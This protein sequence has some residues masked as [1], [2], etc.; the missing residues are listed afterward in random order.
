MNRLLPRSIRMRVDEPEP[1]PVGHDRFRD[2]T[3][4][5]Y[6]TG[7]W[8]WDPMAPGD[9]ALARYTHYATFLD[10]AWYQ[11]GLMAWK[12][13]AWRSRPNFVAAYNAA[14][15]QTGVDYRIEWRTH[16]ALWAARLALRVQ[17]DFIELGAA[18]GWMSAAILADVLATEPDRRFFLMDLFSSG[19]VDPSTGARLDEVSPIYA[20]GGEA[21][22]P[23]VER[24]LQVRVVEGDVMDT[25]HGVVSAAPRIAFAHF[26]LNAAEPEMLAFS[27]LRSSLL[28]G[29]IVLLDDYG[30]LGF[31]QQHDA[32]DEVADRHG[33]EVLAL[34]TGQGLIVV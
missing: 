23:L 8:G 34:P 32:W 26:D 22:A 7:D 15:E 11:D 10:Q 28:P 33:L 2:V 16:T 5:A 1:L 18:R 27:A 19:K 25:I 13:T 31:E 24:Y 9:A 12:N 3:W 4:T 17:G 6:R 20:S 30:F 29:A 21:L 14:C